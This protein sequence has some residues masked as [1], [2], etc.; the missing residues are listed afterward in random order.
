MKNSDIAKKIVKKYSQYE[1]L[2]YKKDDLNEKD[3]DAH[4]VRLVDA[5]IGVVISFQ[6][7]SQKDAEKQLVD[8]LTEALEEGV[9]VLGDTWVEDNLGG[10]E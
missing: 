2:K 3:H 4:I 7:E 10:V 1:H 5:P 9:I 6:G 8:Y